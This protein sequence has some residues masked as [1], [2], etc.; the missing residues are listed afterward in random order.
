MGDVDEFDLDPSLDLYGAS[1]LVS[2]VDDLSTFY[3]ALLR[4]G[5]FT[6]PETL[7]TMLEIPASNTEARAAMGIFQIDIVGNTCRQHSGFWGTFVLT[8]PELDV[9]MAASSNQAMP[10]PNFDSAETVLQRAFQ[11]ATEP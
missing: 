2:T 8:C 6:E 7:N 1:G 11:L 5:V 4:G 10:A 3:Q 9:T